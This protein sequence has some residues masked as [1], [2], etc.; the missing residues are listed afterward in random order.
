ML[1]KASEYFKTLKELEDANYKRLCELVSD[2]I[3]A[4][5]CSKSYRVNIAVYEAN[6]FIW[7]KDDSIRRH[8]PIDLYYFNPL[9][10]NYDFTNVCKRLLN[11]LKSLGYIVFC[12]PQH[13]LVIMII[14]NLEKPGEN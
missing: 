5:I 11:E 2:S 4:A 10:G 12:N 1:K 9:S 8:S 3:E 6:N 13:G 7:T 14:E